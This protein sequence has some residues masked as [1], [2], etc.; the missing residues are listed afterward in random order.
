MNRK[1]LR[2]LRSVLKSSS[3]LVDTL[4]ANTTLVAG[5][6]QTDLGMVRQGNNPGD[7]MVAVDL[8]ALAPGAR[9]TVSLQATIHAGAGAAQLQ[10]QAHAI[11]ANPANSPSGQTV[12]RSDDPDTT[13]YADATITLLNAVLLEPAQ[14]LFLPIAVR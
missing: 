9:A 6:V 13:A 8:V 4:D 10:N 14:Q 5:S 2:R 12:V 1:P 3:R 11:F 7:E